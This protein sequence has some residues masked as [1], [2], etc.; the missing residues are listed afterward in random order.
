MHFASKEENANMDGGYYLLVRMGN[1]KFTFP[2]VNLRFFIK[3]S[4]TYKASKTICKRMYFSYLRF[5]FAAAFL[6]GVT[7]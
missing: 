1:R 3:E 4:I 2:P 7:M 5:S 6:R